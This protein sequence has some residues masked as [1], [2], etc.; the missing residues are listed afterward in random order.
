[1]KLGDV[2]FCK[3]GSV[4]VGSYTY[5]EPGNTDD[6]RVITRTGEQAYR[7]RGLAGADRETLLD[8]LAEEPSLIERPIV[9]IGDRAVVARPPELVQELL[10]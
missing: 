7:E 8:A 4:T 5:D 6:P 2:F 9:Q 1:M 3:H 10:G